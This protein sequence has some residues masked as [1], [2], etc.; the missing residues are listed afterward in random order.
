MV[1][2]SLLFSRFSSRSLP[3]A[4]TRYCSRCYMLSLSMPLSLLLLPLCLLPLA[5]T[6]NIALLLSMPLAIE[7]TIVLIVALATAFLVTHTFSRIDSGHRLLMLD[8]SLANALAVALA[9]SRFC[10]ACCGC[11][12]YGCH[13]CCRSRCF[14]LP[15][16]LKHTLLISLPLAAALLLSL[17]LPRLLPLRLLHSLPFASSLATDL[18]T[19]CC[20]S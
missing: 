14:S 10:A 5:A 7:A 6:L 1:S 4:A 3:L 19:F 13:A 12:C 9:A 2:R 17:P 15:R 20:C 18:T 16:W 8:V 11:Y